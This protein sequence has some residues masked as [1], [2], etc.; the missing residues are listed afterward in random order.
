MDRSSSDTSDC[1]SGQGHVASAHVHGP[2]DGPA[3]TQIGEFDDPG[4]NVA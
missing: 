1:N 3:T 2:E 4:L